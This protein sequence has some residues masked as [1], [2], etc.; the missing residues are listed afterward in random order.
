MTFLIDMRIRLM[1]HQKELERLESEY[2]Q[3]L[4]QGFE[5]RQA[6]VKDLEATIK[7]NFDAQGPQ[8]AKGG[9]H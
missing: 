5:R 4:S 3:Y 2:Q 7:T 8:E 1:A 9:Q 6:C